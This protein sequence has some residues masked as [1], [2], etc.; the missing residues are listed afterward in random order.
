MNGAPSLRVSHIIIH[1]SMQDGL[2]STRALVLKRGR[3]LEFPGSRE[4]HS[5]KFPRFIEI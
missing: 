4:F 2:F 3:G 1:H 5:S